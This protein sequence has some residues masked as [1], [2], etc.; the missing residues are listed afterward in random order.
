MQVIYKIYA[1]I[2]F[3]FNV[4]F[5]K[6]FLSSKALLNFHRKKIYP[7]DLLKL[8]N[9]INYKPKYYIFNNFTHNYDLQNMINIFP[10]EFNSYN[11]KNINTFQSPHNLHEKDEFRNFANFLQDYL[12]RCLVTKQFPKNLEIKII[13]MWFVISSD[14]A[15]INPH[16]HLDGHLSGV[17]YP[18][19]TNPESNGLILYNPFKNIEK[20]I[21]QDKEFIKKDLLTRF[22][23]KESA[24]ENKLI[25]FDSFIMHSV[26][27]VKL[28]HNKNKKRVSLAWDAV[29]NYK[30]N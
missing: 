19:N 24:D 6:Y 4:Y 12:N 11:N 30:S 10:K 14:K 7:K 25:V 13:R 26:D 3:Y 22:K 20:L 5:L 9:N 29:F 16:N 21:F 2:K 23:I 15:Q 28:S 8:F 17:L 27:K 1:Y 18:S